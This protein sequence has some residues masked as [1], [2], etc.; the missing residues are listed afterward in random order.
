M[1]SPPRVLLAGI[2]TIITIFYG[3]WDLIFPESGFL[4]FTFNEWWPVFLAVTLA[5]IFSIPGKFYSLQTLKAIFTL[6]KAFFIMLFSL[7]KLKGANKK[8]IHTEH[9]TNNN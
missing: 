7:F 2:V 5:F 1:V 4:K 3:L 8:F 9:G 6:P